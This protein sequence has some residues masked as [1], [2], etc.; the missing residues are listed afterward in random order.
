MTKIMHRMS[1]RIGGMEIV[2][3]RCRLLDYDSQKFTD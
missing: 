2:Y 1:A 3:T